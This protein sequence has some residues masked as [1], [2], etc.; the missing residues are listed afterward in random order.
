MTPGQSKQM[1]EKSTT[2]APTPRQRPL[3]AERTADGGAFNFFTACARV[4]HA[5]G[6]TLPANANGSKRRET[7][8][9]Y[10]IMKNEQPTPHAGKT[11]RR[12]AHL[13]TLGE[14]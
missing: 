10:C 11:P 5:A 13:L 7:K 2:F 9:E 8:N 6:R 12:P 4:W 14:N 1:S 3:R